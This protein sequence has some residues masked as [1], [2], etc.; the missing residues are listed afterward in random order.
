MQLNYNKLNNYL[1]IFIFI[2]S[3]LCYLLTAEPNISFW[4]TGEYIASSAKLEVTHSPGAAFFQ[5]LGA[6]FASLA[7]GDGSKYPIVINSM[8]GILTGLAVMFTFWTVTYFMVKILAEKTSFQLEN[9]SSKIMTLGAGLVGALIFAFSDTLWYSA[10]EGEVYAMASCFIA[11]LIWLATKY[12]REE[13]KSYE[14]RWLLLICLILGLS[15]GVHMMVLLAIPAICFIYYQK[16]YEIN[17]KTFLLANL[18]TLVVLAFVFM[19]IFP[20]T[21]KFFG[22][23]EIWFVNEL[24]MP[25]NSGLFAVL[26]LI[27]LLFYFG[28]KYSRKYDL[29]QVNAIIWGVLFLL[30]GFSCWMMIP[31]RANANPPMNLNNPDNALS[32]RDYYNR[33]QYGDW[34]TFYGA[35]YTAYLDR[36]G[37]KK[38]VNTKPIYLKNDKTGRYDV[39]GHHFKYEF[40]DDQ[41]GFFPRMYYPQNDT[42]VQ[43]N[44]GMYWGYPE[45]ELN[46]EYAGDPQAEKLISELQ[47]AQKSGQIEISDYK[48][49]NDYINIKPPTLWQNLNY[50]M[51]YQVGEMFVRYL[52]WNFVGKQNDREWKNN[53]F[54]G[55]WEDGIV[56]NTTRDLPAKYTD[57]GTNHY[58]FLPLLLGLI[59][60]FYQLNRDFGRFYAL[61]S[62]F[63][64]GGVG[65]I[66]YTNVKPWE[67]RER[68]YAMVGSF[69]VFA[70]WAGLGA[71]AILE[72]CKEKIKK[73]TALNGILAALMV[74]PL[75]MAF[76]NWDDHDR[77]HRHTAYDEAYSYLKP[78]GK[79]AILLVYGDN[80]TYPLWGVQ[81]TAQLRDDV[82]V[83]NYTLLG[84]SWYIDQTQRK[85]YTAEK[86]PHSLEYKE[87]REGVNDAV[88]LLDPKNWNQILNNYDE[89]W[90][91]VA[92]EGFQK[93]E[94]ESYGKYIED[95][96]MTAREAIDFLRKPTKRRKRFI[97]LVNKYMY[98]NAGNDFS[99][100]NMLP[101]SKIVVPVN[102][103][104]CLKYG[105]VSPDDADKMQDYITLEINAPS[106]RKSEIAMLDLLANYNWDRPLYISAGGIM[107]ANAT[108]YLNKYTEYQGFVYK[109]VPFATP[110]TV[111]GEYGYVNANNIYNTIKEFRWGNFKDPKAHFDEAGLNN[112]ITYRSAS[113]RAAKA[114]IEA[115]QKQKALEILDLCMEE[116]PIDRYPGSTSLD[117]IIYGYIRAGKEDK[118]LELAQTYQNDMLEEYSFY[119]KLSPIEQRRNAYTMKRLVTYYSYSVESISRAYIDMGQIEKAK[120]FT[121]NALKVWFKKFDSIIDIVSKGGETALQQ[122]DANLKDIITAFGITTEAIK[123]VDSTYVME[124]QLEMEMRMNKLEKAA[125]GF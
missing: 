23:T 65:I 54:Y 80:D 21:M 87:Y 74:V 39:V 123:K 64:L 124:K 125:G 69:Y 42:G 116:I 2:L 28:V 85:T 110:R 106:L 107:D 120:Q 99:E 104:N 78:L 114:L 18:I 119:E 16:N 6:V 113:G 36:N 94:F 108:F 117:A 118:G 60:I 83:I 88:F 7:F 52:L 73:Q 105:I 115:G 100:Y 62:L 13:D 81:E 77:S 86:L 59:G 56:R 101:V 97:T 68:D 38:S 10:V 24:G 48:K 103:E 33:E 40:S 22:E 72:F 102:K 12:D 1:G 47:N 34:P 46:P 96:S 25:F 30:I 44:Y 53:A 91:Y 41:V 9:N 31:I 111:D 43:E 89:L 112:I 63:L 15:V 95:D 37:I 50:F 49:Y 70:I 58:F 109:V 84:T 26:V 57:K 3:A 19:F 29:P 66:L 79:E 20:T 98:G 27:A 61:L 76:E 75:L 11:L 67:P 90:D 121:D 71:G 14:N 51:D 35:Y 17:L 55:N 5:L 4:D 45:I 93:S 32:M 122:N 82:K 8:N 92:N